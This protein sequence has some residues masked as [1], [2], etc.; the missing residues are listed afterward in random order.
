[1][2]ESYAAALQGPCSFQ[3]VEGLEE[4]EVLSGSSFSVWTKWRMTP[5]QSAVWVRPMS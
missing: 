5:V 3:N 4:G 2:T 1:M